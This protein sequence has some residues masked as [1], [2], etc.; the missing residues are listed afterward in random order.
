MCD[1]RPDCDGAMRRCMPPAM[2]AKP[3]GPKP[4]VLSAFL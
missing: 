4:N 3:V 2:D 1:V